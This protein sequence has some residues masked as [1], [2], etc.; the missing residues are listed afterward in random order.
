L[1][2]KNQIAA[3][4]LPKRDVERDAMKTSA[5]LVAICLMLVGPAAAQSAGEKTGVHSMLGIAPKTADFVKEAAASDMFEIQSGKLAAT[6]T[7][8]EVQAFAN[9]MVA[10]HTKT[11]SQLKPLGQEANAPVASEMSSSQQSML[12]K[13]QGLNGQ[14]FAKQYMDDQISAHKDAVSLF[15]RYGK[16]GDNEKIKAWAVQTLPTIQHHLDMAQQLDK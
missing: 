4:A 6:K 10:D 5:L 12:Q 7:Q 2:V 15:E 11:S 14:D 13:L 9:Q 8:G 1:V 3:T 16:G